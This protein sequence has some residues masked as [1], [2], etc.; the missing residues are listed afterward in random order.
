M[1]Q[2]LVEQ[3]EALLPQTQCTQCGFTGCQPYAQG[4][5][6]GRADINQC[7]P[8]GAAGISK[9]ANLLAVAEKPLNLKFGVEQARKVAFI[10]ESD[11]I[12]CTKC[13]PPCP[14]DA[15]LGANKQLHTVITSECTGCELCL[16]PCP[17]NCIIMKDLDKPT[18]W[19]QLEAENAKHRYQK[20]KQRETKQAKKRQEYLKKQ[21][22]LLP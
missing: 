15:I 10:V 5:S 22:L 1:T 21:K 17:V 16:A 19:G 3:I 14:V 12:G 9:L 4:I 2:S 18:P 8:G 6:E 13:I 7:P 11:C 20:K